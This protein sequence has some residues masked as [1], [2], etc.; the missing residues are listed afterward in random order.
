MARSPA[1]FSPTCPNVGHMRS[2]GRMR[3]P[4]H[5][6]VNRAR[7]ARPTVTFFILPPHYINT[8]M[9][10]SGECMRE[11]HIFCVPTLVTFLR[12]MRR[13]RR[14]PAVTAQ[15]WTRATVLGKHEECGKCR[16]LRR[17]TRENKRAAWRGRP[18]IRW[19]CAPRIGRPPDISMRLHAH[20][21]QGSRYIEE[22][23]EGSLLISYWLTNVDDHFTIWVI[24]WRRNKLIAWYSFRQNSQ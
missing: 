20:N 24:K 9:R 11:F 22:N 23:F 17:G 3:H 7:I 12:R 2:A 5:I 19:V 1:C 14:C 6:L 10:M 15:A 13:V 16:R 18:H 4:P 8:C 21:R